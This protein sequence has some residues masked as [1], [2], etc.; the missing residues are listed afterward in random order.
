MYD[1]TVSLIETPDGGYLGVAEYA[2]DLYHRETIEKFLAGYVDLLHAI[3]DDPQ[4]PVS[5]AALTVRN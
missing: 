1:L 2:T 5:L 4:S 3:A